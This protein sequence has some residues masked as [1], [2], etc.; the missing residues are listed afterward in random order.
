MSAAILWLGI[1]RRCK[2]TVYA[3]TFFFVALLFLEFVNWW[4]AWMPKYLFFL[5]IALTS[6][7]VMTG[8]KR[9]RTALTA[10]SLEAGL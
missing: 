1:A 4:W 5:I 7:A 3:G 9:L 6:I 10:G 8:L 2:E